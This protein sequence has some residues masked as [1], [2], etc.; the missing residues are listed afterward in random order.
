VKGVNRSVTRALTILLEINREPTPMNFIDI[1]RRL[2]FPKST[3]HKLLFTL[4]KMD[5]LRRGED[6]NRYSIGLAALELSFGRSVP[7]GDLRAVV[8]PIL[9]KLVHNWNETCNL[10]ILDGGFEIT[11]QRFDPP[12]QV[13]RLATLVGRRHPAYASSGGL[14]SLALVSGEVI[15]ANF[16]EV[17]PRVTRSSIRT[18][19]EL[20]SRLEDIR[21]KKYAVDLE[22]AYEGVRCVG[23]GISVPGWPIVGISFSLPLQRAPLDRLKTLAKPLMA[24]GKE[25][26]K[27]L[28]LTAAP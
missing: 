5:F 4:E 28:S 27:I 6:S 3:L 12:E 22:E 13:V 16:P 23:V 21:A 20:I 14:A 9:Q 8:S 2:R 19:A 18:R 1:Q 24:A 10:G 25:I 17:L 15:T 7:Y 11:L 26:E